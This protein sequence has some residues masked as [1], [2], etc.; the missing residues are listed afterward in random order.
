MDA[1]TGGVPWRV[2]VVHVTVGAVAVGEA[3]GIGDG[4]CHG[5]EVGVGIGIGALA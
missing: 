2:P 3:V 1:V 4:V 5:E